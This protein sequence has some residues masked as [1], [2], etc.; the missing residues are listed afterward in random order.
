MLVH[1][2]SIQMNEQLIEQLAVMSASEFMVEIEKLVETKQLTYMDAV[3]Y[4]CETT[5]LEIE[6]AASIIKSSIKLKAKIQQDAEQL[7]YL[8]KTRKLMYE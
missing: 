8:P 5:G 1:N 4:F 2:D 7:N 3:I 6:S